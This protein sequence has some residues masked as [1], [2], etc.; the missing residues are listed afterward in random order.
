MFQLTTTAFI[1]LVGCLILGIGYALLLYRSS[2]NLSGTLRKI[3]FTARTLVVTILAFLLFAPLV[4][5]ISTSVEKPVIILA[6]DNSASVGIA[7]ARNFNRTAYA[8]QYQE[9][10]KQLSQDYETRSF[11]FGHDVSEGL[12]FKFNA[13]LTDITAFFRQVADK[14]SDRNIGAIVLATD[15]IYNSGGNPQYEIHG[16]KAPVYTIA[17]GDT[18]PKKDLII[19][20]VNYNNMAYL[21]NQ[22]QIEVNLEAF[23]SR[24]LNTTVSVSDKTGLIF[25]KPVNITS[26]EYRQSIPFSLPAKAKGIQ[27]YTISVS[28]VGGELSRQ[29]NTQTI[30]VE[31]I[32]GRKKILIIANAPHP[33]IA[34]L[35]QAVEIN[36]NYE[37]KVVAATGAQPS[38]ISEAGLVILHQLPSETNNARDLLKQLEAKPVFFILG[39]QVNTELFSLIQ[40]VLEITSTGALQEAIASVKKD[41]YGF[42]L[43]DQTSARLGNFAPLLTPFGSYRLKGNTSVLLGQQIGKVPTA[44]PLLVFG[45]NGQNKTGILTGEGIWRWR[46]EE[47]QENGTHDAV[48]ELISKSIQ[49]LSSNDDRR[50]FRTYAA[51]N[52]FDENEHIILNA[53]LYNDSYELVNSPDV[54]VTLKNQGGKSYSYIFPKTGN[55]YVLDAGIL[56]PG[57][58]QFNAATRFGNKK[59]TAGGKFIISGQSAEFRQTTANHQLLYSLADQSGGKMIFPSQLKQLPDLIKANE[60]IK[61]ISYENRRYEELINLKLIF[62]LLVGL[63]SAEWFLRKRNGEI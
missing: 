34:A 22:F 44:M 25:S 24:G 36:K 56:P 46:L 16:I 23:L 57:E 60:N 18:V 40:P 41:F 9:I 4:K 19:A 55:A 15:G 58:Y 61:T 35:K 51:K 42:T 29:N 7:Q 31:V 17:L 53:E 54:K 63:L 52:T 1:W 28:P 14:F 26:D 21:D 49:Y 38:D 50:K 20:N 33:D 59:H 47:F 62:F 39:A 8:Q 6:Q 12:A 30:Y 37:V 27:R 13:K 2:V 43:S 32:D 3:L 48:N 10:E 11:S 5:S 45:N